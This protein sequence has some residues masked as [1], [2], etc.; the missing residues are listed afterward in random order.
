MSLLTYDE[1]KK[2]EYDFYSAVFYSVI[3][4]MNE[5]KI[6]SIDEINE[7]IFRI[8]NNKDDKEKARKIN[9]LKLAK[10][11]IDDNAE[12]FRLHYPDLGGRKDR[13]CTRILMKEYP[14]IIKSEYAFR[15][16]LYKFNSTKN[17]IA[18]CEALSDLL[19]IPSKFLL[20]YH[21]KMFL[22]I[23]KQ[24]YDSKSSKSYLELESMDSFEDIYENIYKLA[25]LEDF[26]E[27]TDKEVS[28]LW[29]NATDI[30]NVFF[31]YNKISEKTYMLNEKGYSAYIQFLK[32]AFPNN[33]IKKLRS[34]KEQN[35][36][37]KTIERLL[38]LSKKEE[39]SS[40]VYTVS[41]IIEKLNDFAPIQYIYL[42]QN[43]RLIFENDKTE[44]KVAKILS[45]ISFKE[46]K[47]IEDFIEYLSTIPEYRAE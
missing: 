19:G 11:T 40:E 38:R 13:I 26:F 32:I 47:M 25:F 8:S 35:E 41:K 33:L 3:K 24:A 27:L 23:C 15:E 34:S 7:N 9:L 18:I 10:K 39:I 36:N 37:Y 16:R 21:Q 30:I 44:I 6:E 28:F 17:N 5:M 1:A 20:G 29:N 42:P 22:M 2:V 45:L 31:R 43:T 4:Y 12:I 14:E 46:L